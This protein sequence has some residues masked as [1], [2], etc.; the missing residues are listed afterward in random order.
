VRS[1]RAKPW[2]VSALAASSRVPPRTLPPV[3]GGRA[4]ADEPSP[5]RPLAGC[6]RRVTTLTRRPAQP[7]GAPP[8]AAQ[9]SIRSIQPRGMEKVDG[10]AEAVLS[11]RPSSSTSTPSA[12][13]PRMETVVS[14]RGRRSRRPPR[15]ARY[16]ATSWP[17][18]RKRGLDDRPRRWGHRSPRCRRTAARP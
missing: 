6:R 7:H 18:R 3:G 15:R 14:W 13:E 16:W 10:P 9:P 12:V 11:G 4:S 8:R 1:Q 2:V 5:G 17:R